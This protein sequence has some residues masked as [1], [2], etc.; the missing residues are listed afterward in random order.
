MSGIWILMM[1]ILTSSIP[2]IA[3]YLWFRIARYPFST[4]RFL[5]VL[6][7]GAA[8][9]FP[10]L[11]LQ[12]IFPPGFTV[13]GR[14][15]LLG[16]VFI[17]IAFTEELSRLLVFFGF[18]H[19]SRR[20]NSEHNGKEFGLDTSESYKDVIFGSGMGLVAGLGFAI[21]ESSSYAVAAADLVLIRLFTATPLHAACGARVGAAAIM[22]RS[23]PAQ[24]ALRFFSAIAVHGLYNFMV[25]IPG[26]PSLAAVLIALSAL[27]SSILTIHSGIPKGQEY[28]HGT[29]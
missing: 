1:L 2:A 23:H 7:T 26:L 11:V 16:Q 12:N 6:L 10:A 14:W 8:A 15:G 9:F 19:I 24:A 20:I 13:A 27:A 22:F 25:I 3:V 18:I 29:S 17:R 5:L 28:F 21:L 4:V